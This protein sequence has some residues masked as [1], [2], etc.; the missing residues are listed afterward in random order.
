VKKS[1]VKIQ[2]NSPVVLGFAIACLAVLVL[3]ILSGGYTTIRFFSVY[4]SPASDIFTYPRFLLHVLGH[5]NYA[6]FIGNIMMILA[7][8]PGLEERYGG[9]NLFWAM[10]ITALVSGMIQWLFFEDSILLGASGILLMM[11]VMS[12]VAGMKSG[13]I[14][15][16]L[17][18]VLILH[19][20]GEI[21]DAVT[22]RDNVSQMA[23]IVGGLC[24]AVLGTAMRK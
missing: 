10:F 5:S 13:C 2:N 7:I 1:V 14:P 21:V 9:R 18:L 3:D 4:R 22:V 16:T 6:H 24:G 17:V 23:H 15:V 11:I 20:G 19:V 8:G 12:S